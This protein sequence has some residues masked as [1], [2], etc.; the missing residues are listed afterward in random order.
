MEHALEQ[1][2]FTIALSG[3]IVEPF[4]TSGLELCDRTGSG[5][6]AGGHGLLDDSIWKLLLI[7]AQV[8]AD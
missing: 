1:K 3:R 4:Q 5:Q 7:W 8:V 6:S 2:S